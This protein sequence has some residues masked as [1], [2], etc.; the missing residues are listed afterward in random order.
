M[1]NAHPPFH[2]NA[3]VIEIDPA[4][5]FV[6]E[7]IGFLHEDKAIAF[8]RLMATS[9]QRD[10]IKVKARKGSPPWQLVTGRHRLRGAEIEGISVWAI[11]VFGS[12]EELAE[13]EA[14]E[15]LHRRPLPPIERAM[16]VNALRQAAQDRLA[17]EH[18]DLKQ[19][20]LAVKSRWDKVRAR[21]M[22]AEQAL[23]DESD[24]TV[25]KMSAV[26]GWQESAAE[27]L[28]LGKREVRRALTIYRLI[29]EPS[30]EHAEALSKHPV[31]GENA[32][33]L[34]ILA[35]IA[36]ETNRK[37]VIELLISEQG[38]EFSVAGALD[39]LG[40]PAPESNGN[41]TDAHAEGQTKYLNGVQSYIGRLSHATWKTWA[42]QFAEN[43]KPQTLLTVRDAVLA[44]VAK[45][46]LADG[47]EVE[48]DG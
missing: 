36:S 47:A 14:S 26:Y 27:A 16:F 19:Q 6:P 39:A 4:D 24:D 42:P 3:G 22:R 23:R 45:R 10:L 8:G 25:D 41:R 33:Q 20:Q 35:G 38:K 34:K 18:G 9:G 29:V 15:N 1:N 43:L 31:V 12:D 11:E 28:N 37:K 30:P 5:V 44:E 7:R 32:S 21:D 2:A 17:R 40:L 46:G 13:M 48:G